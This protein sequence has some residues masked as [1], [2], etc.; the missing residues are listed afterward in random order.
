MIK[1]I[2]ERI[3][4]LT[5]KIVHAERQRQNIFNLEERN[6]FD[7]SIKLSWREIDLILDEYNL[8]KKVKSL[9]KGLTND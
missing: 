6:K 4:L 7:D 9:S 1:E 2:K 8:N 5:I 3:N